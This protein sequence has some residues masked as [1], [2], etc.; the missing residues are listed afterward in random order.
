[1]AER[2]APRFEEFGPVSI[3]GLAQRYND[4]SSVGI[5]ALWQRFDPHIGHIPGQTG[6]KTY[7]V[8]SA[9]DSNGTFEYLCGVEVSDLS[10]VPAEFCR[11]SLPKQKYAVFPHAGPIST[12][13]DTFLHIR[14]KWA[15]ASGIRISKVSKLEIYSESFDA[16][17]PGGVEIWIPVEE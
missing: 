4:Q 7:G 15:P 9:V 5:P 6:G 12:L 16:A 10:A 1:M 14:N 13:R 17:L 3:A 11:A 8:M 2:E